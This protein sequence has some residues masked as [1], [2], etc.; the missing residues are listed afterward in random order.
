MPRPGE[1]AEEGEGEVIFGSD[2]KELANEQT[3]LA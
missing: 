3:A 2:L 1:L